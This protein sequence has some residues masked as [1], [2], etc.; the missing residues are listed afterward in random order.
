MKWGFK[1]LILG[2]LVITSFLSFPTL[3]SAASGDVLGVH[4]LHPYEIDDAKKLITDEAKPDEWQ[5]VTIPLSLN[6]LDKKDEWQGFLNAAKEKKIIPIV[7]LTSR[8]ENGAWKVPNRKE[9][10]LL[11]TFLKKQD[12]P[13]DQRH[14]VMFNEVNHA[15]EWGGTINPEEYADILSFAADWAHAEG[16]N[17]VVLPAA[18]DLAAPNGTETM[19]AFTYLNRMH[20]YNPD[21]FHKI[22]VWNS[23]SYPNPGFSSSPERTAQNSLRG[24]EHELKFIKDKTGRDLQVMITETGWIANRQTSRWLEEY[25][26]YALQHVWSHPQVIAVTPFLLRGDPGPFSNF[27]FLDRNN[28]PTVQYLAFKKAVQRARSGS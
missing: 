8:F 13:T 4:I 19:E 24:F 5:Y 7:R 23:H 22:D 17:F 25:Y 28:Q 27:T 26:L 9:I 1:S 6:D 10:V 14:V 15:K 18:M 12:W 11:M 2:L 16:K 21:I 3:V 20:A